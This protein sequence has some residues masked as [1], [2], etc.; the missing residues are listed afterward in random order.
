MMKTVSTF[1]TKYVSHHVSLAHVIKLSPMAVTMTVAAG[2]C[3]DGRAA[4]MSKVSLSGY[5]SNSALLKILS[6][7]WSIKIFGA[8]SDTPHHT[9]VRIH[10]LVTTAGRNSAN[11]GRA[12]AEPMGG[13]LLKA[14]V[15]CDRMGEIG[16][17]QEILKK[18]SGAGHALKHRVQAAYETARGDKRRCW[19]AEEQG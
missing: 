19:I 17:P 3:I 4:P 13:S 10:V 9:Q 2:G 7:L 11:S 12:V 14:M 18:P 6:I 15:A 8:M 1:S 16:K 5:I